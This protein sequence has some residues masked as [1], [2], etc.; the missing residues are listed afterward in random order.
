MLVEVLNY[1]NNKNEEI[2]FVYDEKLDRL[3][4]WNLDTKNLTE[5]VPNLMEDVKITLLNSICS[6]IIELNYIVDFFTLETE[7]FESFEAENK[8][9]FIEQLKKFKMEIL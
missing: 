3:I 6:D 4:K 1:T 5:V 8:N 7:D 9:I 2:K